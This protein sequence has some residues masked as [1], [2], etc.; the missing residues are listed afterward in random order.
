[1][2]RTLWMTLPIAVSA[3][4]LYFF[5]RS[6]PPREIWFTLRGLPLHLLWLYLG[7]YFASTL[8]RT[9]K[10]RILLGGR[11][12]FRDLFL[13]TLVR[14]FA[15]DLLPAR[16]A[17]LVLFSY[18][19]HKKGV[20]LGSGTSSF[21]IAMFYDSLA[22][23]LMLALLL[24]FLPPAGNP[25]WLWLG[26]GGIA[27]LSLAVIVYAAPLSRLAVRL[28]PARW[29]VPQRFMHEVAEYFATHRGMREKA[30]VFALSAALRLL[31]YLSL[32]LLFC[33]LAGIALRPWVFAR[34]CFGL[35]GT[36]FSQFLPIQGIGGFGT[37]ELTFTLIFRELGLSL[38]NPFLI[39]LT[40]HLLTQVCEYILGIAAF[41]Y[42]SFSVR[43]NT[44]A[45]GERGSPIPG[46]GGS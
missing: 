5:F 16:S 1:M 40:L 27:L 45:V 41:L 9:W 42:L 44:P 43:R 8:L 7:F 34:F 29:S 37:W 2:K 33:G 30:L 3:V 32:C 17:A 38:A 21:S 24:V 28:I 26:M 31:K 36:E 14:N 6:T 19:T 23:I 11:L 4:I 22:L 10:Y 12:S 18:F 13:I 46:N 39:A 25:L 15:V 20:D 35:A